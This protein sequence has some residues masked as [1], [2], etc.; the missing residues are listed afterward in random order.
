[1]ARPL[2]IR[3]VSS[4]TDVDDIPST[5]SEIAVV[6]RSNVGKSSL[7]NALAHRRDL[8]RTSKTPGATRLLNAFEVGPEGS[9]RW[10]V[11]LPGY[12]YA[13][14]SKAELE[15]WARMIERYLTE[16]DEL[17]CVIL[18]IDGEIGPTSL[19]LQ[20]QEWLEH[21]GLPI[22]HV[23]TKA[24]KIRPSKSKKRRRDLIEALGVERAD[25]TWVSATKG[26]GVP[27]LRALIADRLGV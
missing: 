20:T 26:T 22:V 21:V 19:D 15:R 25:V 12:G 6:G 5:R 14:R 11:D 7:I 27:E 13:K 4:Y 16:R 18:L 10:L 2:P 17:D 3:F 1:M 24:D 9:E 8:A 23:A